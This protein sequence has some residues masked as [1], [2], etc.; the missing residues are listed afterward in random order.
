MSG[1]LA[2]VLRALD[3]R[4]GELTLFFRDDDAGWDDARLFQLLD[5]FESHA[6]PLDLAVIPGALTPPLAAALLRRWDASGGRLGLHQHGWTHQNHQV[7]G[8]PCEFGPGRSAAAIHADLRAGRDR[9]QQ[10]LGAGVDPIFT[11][12]WNRCT[13][14]TGEGLRRLGFVTLS[15]DTTAVPLDLPGLFELPIAVDWFARARGVRLTLPALGERLAA[16]VGGP[17]PVGLMLHH[18][19]TGEEDFVQ[20]AALLDLLG[21]QPR[22]RVQPM[23]ALVTKGRVPA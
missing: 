6:V 21:D 8:R 20:L 13:A 15:R 17:G 18:G 2:P 10:L 16:A 22:V 14:E 11:P 23:R 1:W 4:S 3:Q 19:V 7:E 12:P 5:L 9:L